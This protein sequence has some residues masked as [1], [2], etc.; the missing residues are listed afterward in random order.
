MKETQL[1][2]QDVHRSFDGFKAINGLSIA[3]DRPLIALK[4]SKLRW[5]SWR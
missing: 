3:I 4:P 5:T 1:Y 2:L